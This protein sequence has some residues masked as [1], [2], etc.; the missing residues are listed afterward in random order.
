MKVNKK[1]KFDFK[2]LNDKKF[3]LSFIIFIFL[4]VVFLFSSF[5]VLEPVSSVIVQSTTLDNASKVEGSWKYT[6]SAK[7]ISKGKARLNI[8]LETIEKKNA[9][10][11]DVILVLDTSGSM[12]KDK[13]TQ[14]QTD[15]L[16]LI[17]D[18]IPK[19][20]K[21]SLIT[22]NDTANIV[23]EFT[24]DS[25]L[26]EGSINSLVATGE[27]NYYQALVKVDEVLS[28]YLKEDNR[29]CVV[30]FLTDG[31]PTIETPSEVGEYKLLK[32]KYEYLNI[33]GIQYELGNSILDGIK[34][35][36]DIQYI[37]STKTLNEFLYKAS[38]APAGY[39][40][41]V[42]TDYI[43]TDYFNLDDIGDITTSFGNASIKNN[44]VI[45]NLNGFKTGLD[46]ELTFDINLNDD[47]V[48]RGGVYQTN[49]G[50]NVNYQI[51]SIN[52]LEETTK[53][54]VL[55][56]N[57][58]VTYDPNTPAGCVVS[59]VPSSKVYSV[60][61]TVRLDDS[62]PTCMGYQFKEWKIVTDVEKV[63]NDQFVMPESNV[64]IKAIWKNVS[65]EKSMNGTVYEGPTLYELVAGSTIGLDTDVDFSV[66][67]TDDNSGVYTLNGTEN[68]KY[69]VYYYRGNIDNNNVLFAGFCWK[70]VRTTST[71][72]VKLI[73]NGNPIEDYEN[74]TS[75]KQDKY[76]NISNDETYPYTYDTETNKWISTNKTHSKTG[77]ISF[78]VSESGIYRLT[79]SVSSEE[80]FDK[81]YFYKDG[82]ELKVDSGTNSGTISLGELTESNVIMVKYTKDVSGSKGTDS[83]TF[84][85]DI[86]SGNSVKKCNNFEDATQIGKDD[87]DEYTNGYTPSGGSYMY[88][89]IYTPKFFTANGSKKILIKKSL[90]DSKYYYYGDS[91]TRPSA[92]YILTNPEKKDF[93]DN[94][95][96]YIGYYTC[97]DSYYKA[98]STVYYVVAV[99]DYYLFALPLSNGAIDPTTQTM[100]L[101][102]SIVNN[103]DGTYT[104]NDIITVQMTDWYN[105]YSN[106]KNYYACAD[107][108]SITCDDIR[109]IT[110]SDI[111][112]EYTRSYGKV[113]GN[114]VSWD[115]SKYTLLDTYIS[116][117]A[118]G[119]ESTTLSEKYHY[120]CL[121]TTTECT[122]VYYIPSFVVG[123][124]GKN[125][126]YYLVFS[127]GDNLDSAK[128]KMYANVNSSKIKQDVDTWYE[129][130]LLS[131]TE[132]I[133][134]TLWC[135]DRTL[136]GGSLLGKDEA[137]ISSYYSSDNRVK[138]NKPSLECT[139][140]IRDA[141]SV[142]KLTGGNGMLTYPIG[143]L[144]VDEVML[145]GGV[146]KV[147]NSNFYLY[148]GSDYWLM[149]PSAFSSNVAFIYASFK[150]VSITTY[151]KLNDIG[152]RP[153]ISLAFEN[154]VTSGNGTADKPY[155]IKE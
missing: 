86:A 17:S 57:Y 76:I 142:S 80:R 56:D 87:Y 109:W 103:N 12:V 114:D 151:Y 15:V 65:L 24:D 154:K 147:N 91:V 25:S 78:S 134:D 62:T 41:L 89:T 138:N 47:L 45:W 39:D 2:F 71:G 6:K 104:L 9:D 77:T 141:F 74:I 13:L 83:V 110:R 143:L 63:S 38:I 129:T 132:R 50:T 10:N 85:V 21:I 81:A 106:Y 115:G 118:W 69:P 111:E 99:N 51:A 107:F 119:E 121:T 48:G 150:K 116:K 123:T 140:M 8:K 59:N 52:T 72:G 11:T 137:G 73:Y 43:D 70:M 102:K 44:Q 1:L 101:G 108:S 26:L 22:F 95:S 29:D 36:T 31:L 135:N 112:I 42:L 155:I 90:S 53:T 84:S 67:P 28:S 68:D 30:L 136:A 79:Y 146:Y 5:A 49:T 105:T 64:V 23:T 97:F 60:F 33:N 93:S 4:F 133:E 18:T 3:L 35:V 113:Y 16:G 98:C 144:T 149:T 55:K 130:N 32:D 66:V 117:K 82:V 92:T 126:Y 7:W 46:A 75:I 96:N 27:T 34:N 124:V 131:Y 128:E 148:S 61:D 20:N 127:N 125:G 54:P 37:A 153:S 100:T 88:G 94:S 58:V 40:N 145:A 122:N 120:T 139:N 19:G 14:L 152:I